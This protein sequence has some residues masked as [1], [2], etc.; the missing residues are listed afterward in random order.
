MK[1]AS[2]VK[3]VS[4]FNISRSVKNKKVTK[5]I[6]STN[7][8]TVVFGFLSKLKNG[9]TIVNSNPNVED[10]KNLG[11]RNILSQKSDINISYVYR[12]VLFNSI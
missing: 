11:N 4:K 6:I 1:E 9:P 5:V 7:K 3:F 8:I 2:N 12:L 10:I